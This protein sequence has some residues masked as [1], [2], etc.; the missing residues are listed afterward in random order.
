MIDMYP[1]FYLYI[2]HSEVAYKGM[3]ASAPAPIF[4]SATL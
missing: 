1:L 2:T 3:V 4:T